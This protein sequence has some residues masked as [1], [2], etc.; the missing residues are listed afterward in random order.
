[1]LSSTCSLIAL[2]KSSEVSLMCFN[3]AM[4]KNVPDISG[5]QRDTRLPDTRC[6]RHCWRCSLSLEGDVDPRTSE[7]PA[8]DF[9]YRGASMTRKVLES[10]NIWITLLCIASFGSP[11][12]LGSRSITAIVHDSADFGKSPRDRLHCDHRSQRSYSADYIRNRNLRWNADDARYNC[13]YMGPHISR[14]YVEKA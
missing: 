10:T 4:A 6:F 1:M 13:S 5:H 12:L 11:D 3:P 14:L 7:R 9:G 8:R 2:T